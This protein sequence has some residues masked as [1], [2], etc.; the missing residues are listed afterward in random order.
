MDWAHPL[1]VAKRELRCAEELLSR[2]PHGD[3]LAKQAAEAEGAACVE[4]AMVQL[5]KILGSLQA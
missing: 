2:V 4:Q 3:P 1:I 5:A